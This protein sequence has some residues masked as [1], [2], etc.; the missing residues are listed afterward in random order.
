MTMC[1][2]SV[3]A[4]VTVLPREAR[5]KELLYMYENLA[6]WRELANILVIQGAHPHI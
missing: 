5:G 6:L 4:R 1:H 3:G 2:L